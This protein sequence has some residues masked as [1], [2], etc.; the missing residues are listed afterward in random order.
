MVAGE[1]VGGEEEGDAAA[2]LLAD[3]GVLLGS[4]GA[5]EEDGGGVRGCAGWWMVTHLLDAIPWG[6]LGH[7]S[8]SGTGMS[9]TGSKPSLPT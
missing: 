6:S 9:S 5:G 8:G 4:G 7:L 2:G 1:V 3:G